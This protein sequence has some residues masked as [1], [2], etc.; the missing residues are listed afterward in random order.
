MLRLCLTASCVA[1]GGWQASDDVSAIRV[2]CNIMLSALDRMP[3]IHL[4]IHSYLPSS[5]AVSFGFGFGF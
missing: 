1:E 3:S 5:L 2:R 4:Y